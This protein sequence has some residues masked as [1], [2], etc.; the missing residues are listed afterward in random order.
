MKFLIGLITALF[1]ATIPQTA[2]ADSVHF[3][4]KINRHYVNFVIDEDGQFTSE[5]TDGRNSSSLTINVKENTTKEVISYLKK[6]IMSED[7]T[8]NIQDKTLRDLTRS[9]YAYLLTICE[10]SSCESYFSD[11]HPLLTIEEIENGGLY[12]PIETA[13]EETITSAATTVFGIMKFAMYVIIGIPIL[14]AFIIFF[15]K[16]KKAM[17]PNNQNAANNRYIK[18]NNSSQKR[19]KK[20]HRNNDDPFSL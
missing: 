9:N 1:L 7:R 3:E 16:I 6:N 8:N 10:D 17:N 13:L 11:E 2:F 12:T 4:T 14:I 19:N 18:E 5:G 15:I 20:F